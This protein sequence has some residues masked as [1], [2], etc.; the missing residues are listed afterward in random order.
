VRNLKRFLLIFLVLVAAARAKSPQRFSL[1]I[2]ARQA[3]VKSREPLL[4][5][6]IFRNVSIGELATQPWGDVYFELSV[7]D[8]HGN[9]QA[10]KPE[11]KKPLPPDEF[12]LPQTGGPIHFLSRGKSATVDFELGQ[13]FRYFLTEPGKYTI[14]AQR[15]DEQSK[16][17]VKSNAIT[18]TVTQ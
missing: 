10:P 12:V 4:M 13:R 1:A 9:S 2:S 7:H 16:T 14:Q 8:S 18:V 3:T 5:Q 15:Y 11:E 17:L 6:L